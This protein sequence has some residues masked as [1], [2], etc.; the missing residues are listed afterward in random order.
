MGH[1]Q[2]RPFYAAIFGITI[3]ESG[4]LVGFCPVRVTDPLSGT[5]NPVDVQL[6][7]QYI[8]AAR[9]RVL[10]KHYKP[11]LENGKPKEFFTW[12]FYV[13]S[14]PGRADLDPTKTP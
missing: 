8:E 9:A 12:F 14:Q 10:S 11:R 2:E 1:A 3:D 6:P 4:N 13:P 5:T 7:A